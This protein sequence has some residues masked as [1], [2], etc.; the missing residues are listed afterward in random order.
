MVTVTL[1][2]GSAKRGNSASGTEKE[3]KTKWSYW[4]WNSWRRRHLDN[5]GTRAKLN[6]NLRDIRKKS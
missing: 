6:L 5:E 1:G 2:I 4:T 3:K